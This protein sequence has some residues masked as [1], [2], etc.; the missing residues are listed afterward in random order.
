MNKCLGTIAVELTTTETLHIAVPL[1][2]VVHSLTHVA[3]TST[4]FLLSDIR[5]IDPIGRCK[6][7]RLHTAHRLAIE[8]LEVVTQT[9]PSVI[10]Q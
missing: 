5:D 8:Q 6:T 10:D 1:V 7:L 2:D 9:T 4:T 3:V